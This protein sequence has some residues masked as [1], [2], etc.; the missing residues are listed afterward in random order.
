MGSDSA[1]Q[2]SFVFPCFNEENGVAACVLQAAAL[3]KTIGYAGEIIVVDNDSTDNSADIA[4]R[5]GAVVLSEERRGY[6]YA[7]RRGLSAARGKYII[8]LDADGSYNVKE[9]T[10]F[11][12]HLEQGYQFV[13]G[14]RLRGRVLSGAMPWLHRYLGVPVLTKLLNIRSGLQLSD[15]HCGMRGL[16]CESLALMQL[17]TGG[18]EFASE[19]ILEAA[20]LGLCTTEIEITYRPRVGQSKLSPLLDGWRHLFLLLSYP[21]TPE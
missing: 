4:H 19:M 7:C 15:A 14:T 12:K 20:R 9:A 1:I 17:Q 3:I 11:I 18:M 2:V 6:G 21:L 13:M 16:H 5:C 8:L 10:A